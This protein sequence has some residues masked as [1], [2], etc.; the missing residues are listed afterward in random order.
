MRACTIE[1]MTNKST[2]LIREV[3]QKLEL[4]MALWLNYPHCITDECPRERYCGPFCCP[5]AKADLTHTECC[6]DT[7]EC[8]APDGV[9]NATRPVCGT[10]RCPDELPPEEVYESGGNLRNQCCSRFREGCCSQDENNTL[11]LLWVLYNF[12]RP[13]K[14]EVVEKKKF[15]CRLEGRN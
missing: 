2:I 11:N 6:V 5:N 14:I 15:V 12:Q 9:N 7:T 1:I 10:T 3:D 4:E 13:K 8:C